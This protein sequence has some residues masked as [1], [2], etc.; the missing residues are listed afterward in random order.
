M[1]LNLSKISNDFNQGRIGVGVLLT[2]GGRVGVTVRD[3]VGVSLVGCS[4]VGVALTVGVAV[5]VI[6]ALGF[7]V[8]ELVVVGDSVTF[9][10]V[11]VAEA[12]GIGLVLVPSKRYTPPLKSTTYTSPLTS[13]PNE[14]MDSEESIYSVFCQP[15]PSNDNPQ[16]RPLQKSP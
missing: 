8:S 16:I 1:V 14:V 2:F 6:V 11:R 5:R 3:G 10:G 12:L 13:S 9:M 4:T 15:V 7:G